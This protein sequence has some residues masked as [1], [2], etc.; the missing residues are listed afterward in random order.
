MLSIKLTDSYFEYLSKTSRTVFSVVSQSVTSP[1]SDF[2]SFE[3]V[4]SRVGMY[5]VTEMSKKEFEVFSINVPFFRHT[6]FYK[7]SFFTRLLQL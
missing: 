7:W 3:P 5:P 6:K 1:V 2:S 4:K